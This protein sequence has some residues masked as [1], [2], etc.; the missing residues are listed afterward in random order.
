MFVDRS[1]AAMIDAAIDAGVSAYMSM[2]STR[3]G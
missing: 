1:D 2:A 3:T